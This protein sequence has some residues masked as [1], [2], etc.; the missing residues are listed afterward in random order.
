MTFLTIYFLDDCI[1]DVWETLPNGEVVVVRKNICEPGQQPATTPDTPVV[2]VD[3]VVPVVPIV[4][5]DPINPGRIFPLPL[6]RA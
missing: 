2:P 3:P 4:P 1:A 5:V 6:S